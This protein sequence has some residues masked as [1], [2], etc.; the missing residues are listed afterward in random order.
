MTT[1]NRRSAARWVDRAKGGRAQHAT[2]TLQHAASNMQLATR[3]TQHAT[4]LHAYMPFNIIK[5]AARTAT[6]CSLHP[7]QPATTPTAHSAARANAPPHSPTCRRTAAA[8]PAAARGR[9]TARRRRQRHAAQTTSPAS[10]SAR[11][12]EARCAARDPPNKRA[13]ESSVVD[14]RCS[15]TRRAASAARV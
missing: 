11:A 9:R 13:Y 8:S 5:R 3:N 12:A 2:R 4:E 1:N 7:L 14:N 15:G 6:A 10:C